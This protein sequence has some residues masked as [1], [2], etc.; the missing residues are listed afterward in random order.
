MNR[1]RYINVFVG[2]ICLIL[3]LPGCSEKSAMH[4]KSKFQEQEEYRLMASLTEADDGF[5]YVKNEEDYMVLK[6]VEK[7]SAKETVLCSKVN[8]KHN[9][10]EC[11]AVAA[12]PEY[13]GFMTYSDGRLYYMIS[14]DDLCLYSVNKDGTDKKLVHK[15]KN[16]SVPPNGAG[17]YKGK[18]F[19][20]LPTMEEKEDEMASSSSAPSFVIYDLKTNETTTVIDGTKDKEQF[21]VP[22]G[23]SGDTVYYWQT[24][25]NEEKAGYNFKQYDLKTGKSSDILT[26]KEPQFIQDDLIYLPIEEKKKV[27]SLNLNTG[28]KETVLEW[29]ED[30]AN[31]YIQPGFIELVKKVKEGGNQKEYYKW[32]DIETKQ[33]LFDEFKSGE[34][35]FV[36][37]KFENGYWIEIDGTSYFYNVKEKKQIEIEEI[38]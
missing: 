26:E 6:Y 27:E 9:S 25:W 31:V 14:G 30:L 19:L 2:L 22:C 32:Y 16:Q 20:S 29:K 17:F 3:L 24:K 4:K 33:Y 8:C 1:T 15:F 11:P 34:T 13:M 35:N 23:G 21:T 5:Y 7:K 36:K 38:K 37:W 10:R 28:K 18:L 12:D